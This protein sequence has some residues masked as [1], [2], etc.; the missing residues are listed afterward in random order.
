M[1]R[2]DCIIANFAKGFSWISRVGTDRG[3]TRLD[4]ARGKKQVW[5]PHVRTWGL[6]EA[7]SLY[8]R[9]YLW[10]CW[11]FSAL[12]LVIRRPGNFAPHAPSRYA[13]G[14]WA[15]F[16]IMQPYMS[17]ILAALV[18]QKVFL[19]DI[20]LLLTSV[21]EPFENITSLSGIIWMQLYLRKKR[22]IAV[23]LA[24]CFG[25]VRGMRF[26]NVCSKHV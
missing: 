12:P 11:D 3:V 26:I 25:T 6:S 18:C 10:H 14:H 16:W 17:K 8:W 5:R 13:P 2:Y 23:W 1:F 22:S 19:P 7:N 21:T 20:S 4:G 15:K 24:S 9:K